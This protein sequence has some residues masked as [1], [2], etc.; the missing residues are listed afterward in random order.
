MYFLRSHLQSR[1]LSHT[2][3]RNP[4]GPAHTLKKRRRLY[5]EWFT[6]LKLGEQRVGGAA[7]RNREI[8]VPGGTRRT[9]L[10]QTT[11]IEA[12]EG[13]SRWSSM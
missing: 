12:S 11:K 9:P 7:L 2:N 8:T 6:N 5:S 4:A 1:G 10:V 3:K 13:R